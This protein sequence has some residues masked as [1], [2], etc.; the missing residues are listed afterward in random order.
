MPTELVRELWNRLD[1]HAAPA[2]V[3]EELRHGVDIGIPAPYVDVATVG[4]VPQCAPQD[5]VLAVLG[6]GDQGFVGHGTPP[7]STA[8]VVTSRQVR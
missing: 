7:Y 3:V 2:T 6:V 1:V 5:D 4:H 8:E